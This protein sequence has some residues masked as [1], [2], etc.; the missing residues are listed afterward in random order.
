[1]KCQ[2]RTAPFNTRSI[3]CFQSNGRSQRLAAENPFHFIRMERQG[4]KTVRPAEKQNSGA[5]AA[6]LTGRIHG[7]AHRG[8][9]RQSDVDAV[10]VVG[11]VIVNDDF[12]G[13][14]G[15]SRTVEFGMSG[16]IQRTRIAKIFHFGGADCVPAPCNASECRDADSIWRVFRVENWRPPGGVNRF[17]DA[18]CRSLRSRVVE[19]RNK[20]IHGGKRG[21]DC[22]VWSKPI[23]QGRDG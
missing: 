23:E 5:I 3:A 8:F 19:L 17:S 6:K 10:T 15:N 13:R 1:M 4:F 11:S 9:G 21:C 12:T 22:S 14:V 2:I 20:L 7:G 16:K 18:G